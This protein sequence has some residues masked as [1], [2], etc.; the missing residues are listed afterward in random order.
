MVGLSDV[1]TAPMGSG[2]QA[3]QPART[4]VVEECLRDEYGHCAGFVFALVEELK[5]RGARVEI[6]AHRAFDPG[7]TPVGVRVRPVFAESWLESFWR[8]SRWGRIRLLVGYNLRFFRTLRREAREG[9]EWTTVISTN[10]HVFNLFA[11]GVWLRLAPR[12]TCLVLVA[13]QPPWL[14][15]W[16]ADGTPELKRQAWLYRRAL[17]LLAGA[18]AEGRC[19]FAADTAFTAKVLSALGGMPVASVAVPRTRRLLEAFG[20]SP[21]P[22]GSIR[23]GVLGRPAR[24]KGFSLFLEAL[25]LWQQETAANRPAVCFV[26]QWHASHDADTTGRER[27]HALAARAPGMVAVVEEAMTEERYAALVSSLHGV[28]LPYD[29]VAYRA[30]GSSVAH[31]AFCAGRPVIVTSGT[32]LEEEMKRCGA[33]LTCEE[34]PVGLIR[35]L[36]E[37]LGRADELMA[38]ARARQPLARQLLSA[39]YFFE[40]VGYDPIAGAPAARAV[41]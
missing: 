20:R 11:W 15:D 8:R 25:E 6:W 5:A 41:N 39:G 31:D 19:R 28:L 10:V 2:T 32:W 30:R 16:R 24:E 37:F 22:E 13:I 21:L 12:R 26:V 14:V 18:V 4:L 34:T 40:Q 29:R 3:K 27:L 38:A 33:G 7:L 36:R 17:R 35:A 1:T 23:L 9:T